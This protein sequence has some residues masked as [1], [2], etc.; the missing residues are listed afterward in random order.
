MWTGGV[1]AFV[2]VGVS[3][4]AYAYYRHLNGNITTIEVAGTSD[5]GFEQDKPINILVIGTDKRIGT[6]NEGYGDTG[7][8]GHADTT[9]LFH[10]SKDRTNATALSIPR[11][12]ITDIPDCTTKHA[13]GTSKDIPGTSQTRF[14][15]SLGQDGR[16]PGCTMRT[17]KEITGLT[18]DHFMMADFNAV[19]TLTTAVGGVDVCVAKAVD[20]PESHLK[21]GEGKT[22]DRGRAGAGLRPYPARLRQPERPGPDQDAAAVPGFADAEDD[23]RA[24]RSPASAS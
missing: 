18:V 12:L 17:V 9:F 24:T 13:D 16:D 20:D 11:D 4:A 22:C 19:K 21:L 23:S 1:L 15:T 2:L 10:V 7:S 14:N 6:G 3:T 8:V 5:K